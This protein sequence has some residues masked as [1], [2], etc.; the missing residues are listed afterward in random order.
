MSG[1]I[2][3]P[4]RLMN[5]MK[6]CFLFAFDL[7]WVWGGQIIRMKWKYLS[8]NQ[9]RKYPSLWVISDGDLFLYKI[10]NTHYLIIGLRLWLAFQMKLKLQTVLIVSLLSV[11]FLFF[12][13][14]IEMYA[15]LSKKKDRIKMSKTAEKIQILAHFG[16]S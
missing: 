3:W 9:K 15:Q 11:R 2:F 10:I 7:C 4:S 6:I 8:N 14:C 5:T 13:T 1:T 16:I 12:Y